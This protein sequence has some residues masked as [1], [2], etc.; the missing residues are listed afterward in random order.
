ML[1][2][3][4]L[5]LLPSSETLSIGKVITWSDPATAIGGLLLFVVQSSHDVSFLANNHL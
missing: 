3:G 2:S 5:E 1:P 4:S